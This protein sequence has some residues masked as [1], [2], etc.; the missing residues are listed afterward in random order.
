MGKYF[1]VFF[2]SLL[3]IF[4]CRKHDIYKDTSASLNF[5]TDSIQFDTVFSRFDTSN[6]PLS[7]TKT[8]KIYNPYNSIVYT[9]IRLMGGSASVYRINIDGI[10]TDKITHYKIAPKDSFY[11]FVQVTPRIT[12]ISNPLFVEDS[13]MFTTNGN[14]QKI[15]LVAWGQDAYYL[16]DSVLDYDAV[17]NDK[18]KPYVIWRSVLVA[19]GKKLT[20]GKGVKVCSHVGSYIYVQGTLDMQ[21]TPQEP[22]VLQG[23]RLE[24][25]LDD[26]PNQWWGVR[27]LPGSK[28][29]IIKY[30]VIKNGVVGVEIDSASVNT[31]Y[32]LQMS[33]TII[34][35]M[36]SSCVSAYGSKALFTNCAFFDAGQLS[37]FAQYGGNYSFTFCTIANPHCDNFASNYPCFYMGNADY[38][39]TDAAGNVILR[40][41]SILTFSLVNTII[42]GQSSN[43]E[44]FA[45]YDG[46][47]PANVAT[48]VIDHCFVRTKLFTG[49]TNGNIVNVE[50]K[51]KDMCKFNYLPDTLS[52]LIDKANNATGILIDLLGK[53]RDA[54]PCIGAYETN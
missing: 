16:A 25:N 15:H 48:P 51:F 27:L 35:T 20:I 4:S 47:R 11:L 8:L 53:P 22:V 31:N 21:G 39:N 36:S 29:N 9:D 28:D 24:K 26:V 46:G 32:N 40:I 12:D 23:D 18:T 10:P 1:F 37:V 49:G 52:P 42:Y 54:S 17:W 19:P 41:P 38:T 14:E 30:S 44:E 6:A 3:V 34:R 2:I 43:E 45:V 7:T 33:N 50:P 5:S 13:I